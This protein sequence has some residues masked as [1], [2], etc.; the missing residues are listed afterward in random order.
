MRF[1]KGLRIKRIGM[2]ELMVVVVICI[3]FYSL[4]VLPIVSNIADE[5]SKK[6]HENNLRI[7]AKTVEM[8]YTV[9][10]EYPET[11]ADL[12]EGDI[13]G[14]PPMIPKRLTNDGK[15][16]LSGEH[17]D[18]G[19]LGHYDTEQDEKDLVVRRNIRGKLVLE[20]RYF[21][22]NHEGPPQPMPLGSWQGSEEF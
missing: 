19:S 11:I 12:T 22:L 1:T 14:A 10:G 15:V 13:I 16:V 5:S 9:Y 6:V 8:Y 2:F 4:L 20:A 3:M 7:L 21:L 17:F 18:E